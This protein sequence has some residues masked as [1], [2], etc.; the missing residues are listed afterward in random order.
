M[1]LRTASVALIAALILDVVL[2]LL[3]TPLGFETRPPSDLTV[4]G[5]ISIA[6]V[7]IGVLLDLAAIIVS[8]R[9]RLASTLAIIGSIVF[10]V[11]NV[12]DKAGAFFTV[13]A[14]PVIVALE[15]AFMA[16]LLATLGVAWS[17]FRGSEHGERAAR[18]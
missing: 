1:R 12:T 15:Y 11:P 3:L 9:A 13:P 5:I 2:A 7:A 4:I 16:A 8:R 10:I 18:G 6:A 17:V 14:P